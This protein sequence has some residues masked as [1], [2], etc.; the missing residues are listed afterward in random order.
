MSGHSKWSQ[1]KHK[2][3]AAD[4]K[5]SVLFGKIAQAIA[6][7]AQ[8]GGDPSTNFRL[9]DEIERARKVNMARE[10]IERA[11]ERGARVATHR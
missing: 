4:A 5:K 7:A 1:I 8:S 3:G 9:R 10:S 6:A 2:K 11:I